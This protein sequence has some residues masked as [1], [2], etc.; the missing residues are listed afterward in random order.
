VAFHTWRGCTPADLN[1]W[2][3]A[4]RELG[5]PLLVTESGPDAHLHNYPGVRLEPWFQLREI[6][7]YVRICNLAQPLTLMPW[8][9][10]TDYSVLQGGGVY[11]EAGP[12][13]PT[14]RFWNLKQLGVTPP[15][16]FAL[17][18]TSDRPEVT[19][20]AFGDLGNG[21]F[22]VHLVNSGGQC[23]ASLDGLPDRVRQ[24]SLLVTDARRAMEDLSEVKVEGGRAAFVLPAAS[25]VT[26]LAECESGRAP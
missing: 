24:A 5:V 14:Q 1:Q 26:L 17:P 11:S 19:T 21:V 22:A 8:Q 4:V 9:L 23:E 20:A 25:Y 13:E 3:A 2:S 12:L 16:A 18:M 7:L 6:E 10:T 15:R